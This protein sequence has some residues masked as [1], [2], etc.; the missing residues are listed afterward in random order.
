MYM[1]SPSFRDAV[2]DF[3]RLHAKDVARKQNAGEKYRA[4]RS[5]LKEKNKIK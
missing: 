1:I 3:N 5:S 2:C 4:V